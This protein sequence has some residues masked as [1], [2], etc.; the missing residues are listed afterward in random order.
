M[1]RGVIAMENGFLGAGGGPF[2]VNGADPSF[3]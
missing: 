1:G 2:C 3:I